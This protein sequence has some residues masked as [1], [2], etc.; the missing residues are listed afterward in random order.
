MRYI[1]ALSLILLFAFPAVANHD[2]AT[3]D[4]Y[5][6]RGQYW[7]LDGVA[8]TREKRVWT[9][10]VRYGCCSYPQ[11]YYRWV[12]TRVPVVT[13]ADPDW[14]SKL[15]DIAAQRDR[16]E[17]RLRAAAQEQNAFL[18]AVGAL[19]LTGNFNW[20]SYGMSPTLANP[21]RAAGQL[22]VG[23]YGTSGNTLYGYSYSQ[24]AD[25]YGTTDAN[26]LYQ[27]AAA[28]AKNS[29]DLG[30][31]ATERFSSMVELDGSNRARVAEILAKGQSASQ[32]L[33][34]ADA[35]ASAHVHVQS[36]GGG[37]ASGQIP[38]VVM[39][40][41]A[42]VDGAAVIATRCA[43]CHNPAV[44]NEKKGSFVMVD[45]KAKV[46]QFSVI[47]KGRIISRTS[48]G[49]MPPSPL[50]PLTAEEVKALKEWLSRPE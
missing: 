42:P 30:G 19:G 10:Y 38:P 15:L 8:Y 45:E 22:A 41:A 11:R 33:K 14:R 20:S 7:W 34:A 28:L 39:P 1:L 47:E 25:V 5:T 4:G 26:V 24:I 44:P 13:S 9:E 49:Q 21:Y 48:K 32:T 17:G 43:S 27:Q 12:Y 31:R 18:E 36:T 16:F 29:Q 35:A 40:P 37:A 2:G 50:A 6:Y 46:V 23:N 3:E